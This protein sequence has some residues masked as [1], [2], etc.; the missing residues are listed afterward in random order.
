MSYPRLGFSNY[1]LKDAF[2]S[3]AKAASSIYGSVDQGLNLMGVNGL[4]IS[5]N[6]KET[7][8]GL[9]ERL[10]KYLEKV[11][12]LEESNEELERRIKEL[13]KEKC[14]KVRD[15]TP[16]LDKIHALNDE[17]RKKNLENARIMIQIDNAKLALD[18]FKNKYDQ[19]AAI[20]N[21]VEKDCQ[22]L[23][24]M[25]ADNDSTITRLNTELDGLKEELS[26]MQKNHKDEM[27]ALK[28]NLPKDLVTVEVDHPE[29]PDLNA[30]LNELREQY[31]AIVKKNKDDAESWYQSKTQVIQKEVDQNTE[32]VQ[33]AKNELSDKRR[34]LQ[35]LEL[36]LET[37]RKQINML[38]NTLGETN[39]RYGEILDK[40]QNTLK[41]LEMELGTLRNDMQNNKLDYE[42]LLQIKQNLEAEIATYRRLL[43]G[44]EIEKTT[45]PG[46]TQQSKREPDVI[47]RKIVKVVTQTMVNGKIVNE[48]SEVEEVEEKKK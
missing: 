18:D 42:K 30:V 24:K 2:P 26:F 37:L 46:P 44:E 11:R 36:E 40:L 21:T 33:N 31:E 34:T 43:E 8:Q 15:Y 39:Q 5:G 45:L 29:G 32:A 9:N 38:D 47:T 12:N 3:R 19:E 16:E 25:K 20:C 23:K 48:T 7:M 22:A 17:V 1:S 27:S 35:S 14:P 10:A 41:Q 4:P 6:R 13:M 28:P